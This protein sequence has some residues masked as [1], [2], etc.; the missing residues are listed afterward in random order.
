[1]SDAATAYVRPD[2]STA[3]ALLK[4]QVAGL[5][6]R[7]EKLQA[8]NAEFRDALEV[9]GDE[10]DELAQAAVTEDAKDARIK[11][12]EGT[13]RLGKHRETFSSLAKKAG[14]KEE[15][16]G[17]L[18][19][20]IRSKPGEFGADGKLFDADD[21]DAKAY[22]AILSKARE[23]RGYAFNPVEDVA[24]PTPGQPRWDD[25]RFKPNQTPDPVGAGKGD[26]HA[27]RGLG[28]IARD[29]L[30]AYLADPA[31]A[32]DPANREVIKNSIKN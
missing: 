14:I 28:F 26:G 31:F 18:F 32:L 9:I 3:V 11:E 30:A 25:G 13:L 16:L 21:A 24:A 23:S 17:D 20:L 5:T 1:V 22:E 19:D 8:E 27:G 10:R 15:A 7:L 2:D 6:H 29:Q 4:E 12:L